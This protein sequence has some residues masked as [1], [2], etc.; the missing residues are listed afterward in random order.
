MLVPNPFSNTIPNTDHPYIH[1]CVMM[2]KSARHHVYICPYVP[3]S[4]HGHA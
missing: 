2:K 3:T 4:L 1:M